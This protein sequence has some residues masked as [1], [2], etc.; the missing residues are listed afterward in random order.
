MKKRQGECS[1]LGHRVWLLVIG[2]CLQGN[3]VKPFENI[4]TNK[5]IDASSMG[6]PTLSESYHCYHMLRRTEPKYSV[7]SPDHQTANVGRNQKTPT[8]SYV[9]LNEQDK[10]KELTCHSEAP[11]VMAKYIRLGV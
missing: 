6:L 5:N 4:E 3:L 7:N 8:I 2:R 1:I 9:S 11:M 10:E